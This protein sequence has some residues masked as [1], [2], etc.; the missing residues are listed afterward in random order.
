MT[1]QTPPIV[2][3][4]SIEYR[5]GLLQRS[6]EQN[7]INFDTKISDSRK[8][9][10]KI[11]RSS[12]T[13]SKELDSTKYDS[14]NISDILSG[15]TGELSI[16]RWYDFCSVYTNRLKSIPGF[17]FNPSVE[18]TLNSLNT[19]FSAKNFGQ[20]IFGYLIAPATGV[21]T[22]SISSSSGIEFWLSY[23]PNPLHS[24]LIAAIC[25]SELKSGNCPYSAREK[26]SKSTQYSDPINLT[27]DRPYY[28]E[29]IHVNTDGSGQI[30]VKWKIPGSSVYLNI[31][32]ENLITFPKGY[33]PSTYHPSFSYPSHVIQALSPD[34]PSERDFLFKYPKLR[35]DEFSYSIP[36][37]NIFEDEISNIYLKKLSVPY[38]SVYPNDNTEL[39][40]EDDISSGN[41]LLSEK[42]GLSVVASFLEQIKH[43]FPK[44]I[45]HKIVNIEKYVHQPQIA[46]YLIEILVYTQS[47]TSELSL[48]SE[49][50]FSDSIPAERFCQH[51]VLRREESPFV[52]LMVGIKNSKHWARYLVE[53]VERIYEDTQDDRFSLI[54][55]DFE[56]EDINIE[57]LL[58]ESSL[59]NWILIKVG[60][61]LSLIDGMNLAL[62]QVPNEN[63]IFFTADLI[64]GI[65]STM[66]DSIRKHTFQGY[67]AYA[68]AAIRH[69]CGYSFMYP[70]GY[71]EVMEYSLIGMYKSDWVQIG[72]VDDWD[73]Q[74][75]WGGDDWDSANRVLKSGI[76]LNRIKE[77]RLYHHYHSKDTNM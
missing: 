8:Y 16:Y 48:I 37:C 28:I 30:D 42:E 52:Y 76:N 21:F 69:M 54:I 53:N 75:S 22:F 71:W 10:K 1:I 12:D 64:L 61:E 50:L 63:D 33:S 39:M 11:V 45:L 23:D 55:V 77:R 20:R 46:R 40:N 73:I 9:V 31:P 4:R 56:S 32:P 24:I 58:R 66:V 27:I 49:S 6:Q 67:S 51:Y 25:D 41:I 19:K 74:T 18:L 38:L 17:P 15:V 60:R 3:K 5:Q 13:P 57:L 2:Y 59:K 34:P 7:R 26:Y 35:L 62:N 72:G 44:I 29:L 70:F 65:P 14:P 43:S 68:P 36:N 47:N